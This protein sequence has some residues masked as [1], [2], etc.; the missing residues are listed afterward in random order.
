MTGQLVSSVQSRG[1]AAD[2]RYCL[3]GKFIAVRSVSCSIDDA[4]RI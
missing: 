1:L 3:S 2:K 4:F